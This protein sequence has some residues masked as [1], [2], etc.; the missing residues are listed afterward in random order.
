MERGSS[1][2]P[3]STSYEASARAD[4]DRLLDEAGERLRLLGE[5]R[6]DPQRLEGAQRP[7]D[8]RPRRHA[9]RDEVRAAERQLRLGRVGEKTIGPGEGRIGRAAPDSASARASASRA[10][11][12]PAPNRSA[13]KSWSEGGAE[14]PCRPISA[15]AADRDPVALGVGETQAIAQPFRVFRDCGPERGQAQDGVAAVTP[16]GLNGDEAAEASRVGEAAQDRLE[17]AAFA[18]RLHDVAG[19]R[20]GEELHEFGAHALPRKARQAVARADRGRKALGVERASSVA[21]REAE[22][23]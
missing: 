13:R 4:S 7:S 21:G 22:K 12:R 18:H 20:R 14:I 23:A 1:A 15:A 6:P 8:R 3:A 17:K 2:R 11:S 10:A 5:A 16:R 19:A 9:P